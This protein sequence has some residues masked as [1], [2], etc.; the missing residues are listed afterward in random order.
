MCLQR[1]KYERNNQGN[2]SEK[3]QPFSDSNAKESRLNLV[4]RS[5]TYNSGVLEWST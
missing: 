5:N 2:V 1:P 3:F 4:T